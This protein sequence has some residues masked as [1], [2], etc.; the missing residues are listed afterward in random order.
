MTRLPNDK[1]KAV[2][3]PFL[4]PSNFEP[5]NSDRSR[6]LR[7]GK[8]E[9]PRL[10]MPPQRKLNSSGNSDI[11]SE[12]VNRV[13]QFILSPAPP[14]PPPQ[15]SVSRVVSRSIKFPSISKGP[16]SSSPSSSGHYHSPHSSGGSSGVAGVARDSHNRSGSHR[17]RPGL[18]LGPAAADAS[19][20]PS[21][22]GQRRQRSVP[23]RGP[24]EASGGADG[25]EGPPR[26]ASA[27]GPAAAP[28]PQSAAAR[29]R[30]S[31]HPRPPQPGGL[32]RP[33][34]EGVCCHHDNGLL[35][36][37]LPRTDTSLPL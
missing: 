15:T 2:I 26:E 17:L 18:A 12:R 9:A 13:L 10:P 6:L 30:P 7:E 5:W 1:L 33:L 14:H 8:S 37:P 29:H 25:P 24:E 32:R 3:P 28:T 20:S 35:A 11:V 34:Q 23:D 16:S 27:P 36:P 22:R 4:P 21:T 19:L 31:R